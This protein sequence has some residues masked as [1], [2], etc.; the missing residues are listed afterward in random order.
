M[1][2]QTSLSAATRAQR[3]ESGRNSSFQPPAP[4]FQKLIANL[5]LEFH[6]THRKISLLKISNR[7]YFAIL[8]F[9][10]LTRRPLALSKMPLS[11][12]GSGSPATSHSSLACP[13]EDR[14]RRR[15][16]FVLIYGGAIRIRRNPFKN[17]ILKISNRR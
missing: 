5:E 4:S 10:F 9:V 16:T 6:L 1:M 3:N 11:G 12:V 8:R 17:N 7:K 14:R 2:T 15:V 13:E